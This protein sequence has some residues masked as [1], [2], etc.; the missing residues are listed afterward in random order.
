MFLFVYFHDELVSIMIQ[1]LLCNVT[2]M[3]I[4]VVYFL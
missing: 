4:N 3:D 2:K 1:G